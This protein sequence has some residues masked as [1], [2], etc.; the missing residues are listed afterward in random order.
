[1]KTDRL[2]ARNLTLRYEERIISRDLS[3][4]IPDGSF[5][6]V[7]G[8][9]ACGKSTLLRAL[10]RLLAPAN[11]SVILDGKPIRALSS[12]DVARRLGLLP[13]SAI[14]P[15]GITVADLVA[16]GR[17]P[18]QSFLRQWSR[19]DEAA[20]IAAM[21]ALRTPVARIARPAGRCRHQGLTGCGINARHQE[22][23]PQMRGFFVVASMLRD[24]S[25]DL[26]KFQRASR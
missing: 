13:Q 16:R 12:K 23:A 19:M 26:P 14:A 11:G 8:P 1:M 24:Q 10:S 22:K 3:V 18:H 4:T 25:A 15:E 7:V 6:V 2:H 17:Y 21:E 9:N 20:V 5:T